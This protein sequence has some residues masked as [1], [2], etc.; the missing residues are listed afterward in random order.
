MTLVVIAAIVRWTPDVPGTMEHVVLTGIAAT[1]TVVVA[2]A[3]VRH[4][5][6]RAVWVPMTGSLAA[7]TAHHASYFFHDPAGASPPFDVLTA[8]L[9]GLAAALGAW[10][11]F[12]TIRPLFSYAPTR[13]AALW[14]VPLAMIGGCSVP[15]SDVTLYPDGRNIWAQLVLVVS[16]TS[17]VALF[18][19]VYMGSRSLLRL[20]RSIE[21]RLMAALLAF[22]FVTVAVVLVDQN[23]FWALPGLVTMTMIAAA[24]HSVSAGQAGLP[25]DFRPLVTRVRWTWGI[26][27]SVP[28]LALV[29]AIQLGAPPWIGFI[30][31]AATTGTYV[32]LTRDLQRGGSP[33]VVRPTDRSLAVTRSISAAIVHEELELHYQPIVRLRDG[34]VLGFEALLRWNHHSLGRVDVEEVLHGAA[35][36][37][38]EIELDSYVIEQACRDLP[39]VLDVLRS[40][41]PYLAVNV[42]PTT[43]QC[44]GFSADL[45]QR[46]DS[47][48]FSIDGLAI[49][50]VERGHVS[51]W[52][53]LRDNIAAL[54]D[55]GA[56]IAL[57][58][59]GTG[60][61]NLHY[62]SEIDADIA[63]LDRSLVMWASSSTG[64]A[65]ITRVIEMTRVAGLRMV[66]EGVED[67]AT[68]NTLMELGVEAAQGYLFARPAPLPEALAAITG[69][70]TQL[71]VRPASA[72][73]SGAPEERPTSIGDIRAV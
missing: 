42:S 12:L 64:R 1:A 3:V 62:L 52:P 22:V 65:V 29:P 58:D 43:L 27:A 35:R 73:A 50:I 37:G 69:S 25:V 8:A 23:R 19:T 57:D 17:C 59:F 41:E 48:G 32:W 71:P 47:G 15:L 20:G 18:V 68:L 55:A 40:D 63:K 66:A 13:R 44:P 45:L 46:L 16:I 53:T 72:P 2:W 14:G 28:T 33:A 38:L 31:F 34:V 49:E 5:R 67:R 26:G 56:L 11:G 7:F 30:S 54:Q 60:T 10:A 61:S 39:Q 21:I 6:A 9:A 24:S 4:R 70:L 36:A 51:D